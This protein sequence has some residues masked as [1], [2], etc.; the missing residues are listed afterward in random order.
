MS[1]PAFVANCANPLIIKSEKFL[2]E[3][4]VILEY[5]YFS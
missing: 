5:W 3:V 1:C 4:I 2:V